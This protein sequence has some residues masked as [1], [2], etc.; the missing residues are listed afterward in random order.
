MCLIYYLIDYILCHNK[1][2]KTIVCVYFSF[3]VAISTLLQ[4]DDLLKIYM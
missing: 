4:Y 1:N 2:I 3:F